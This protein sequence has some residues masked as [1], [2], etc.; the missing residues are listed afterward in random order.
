MLKRDR[1]IDDNRVLGI[2]VKNDPREIDFAHET[3]KSIDGKSNWSIEPRNITKTKSSLPVKVGN[4]ATTNRTC[5]LRS[6]KS[7]DKQSSSTM[8]LDSR[9]KKS[10]LSTK[11]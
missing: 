11:L 6:G 2:E 8:A 3:E 5:P 10:I 4:L 7:I 9:D 1:T